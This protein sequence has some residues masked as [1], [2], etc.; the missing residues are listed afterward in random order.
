LN[1]NKLVAYF[2][3]LLSASLLSFFVVRTGLDIKNIFILI[4]ILIFIPTLIK[5]E[6]GLV[7]IIISALFSPD[8]ILGMTAYR[9]ITLRIE[10][11]CLFLVIIAWLLRTA[12]SKNIVSAFKT[13][14]T[15]PYML[16]IVVCIVST[17]IAS[18]S[19]NMDLRYSFLTI[20]K[21]LEYFIL[22]LMA[23][24]YMRSLKQAKMFVAVFFL[25]VF[26]V[27]LL[28]NIFVNQQQAA[29]TTFFR[30][31][32][33]VDTRAAESAGTLGGYLLFMMCVAGG[34]LIYMRSLPVRAFL[35][36]VLILMFRAFLFTLSRG[37]Y[38][39]FLPAWFTLF[40]FAKKYTFAY[41]SVLFLI[42]IIFLMPSMV[43]DR[44]KSTIIVK[45][46]AEG[47]SLK[48][49]DS[50]QMRIDSWNDVVFRTFPLNPIFG[51][52][53]GMRFIDGQYVTSLYEAGGVG[54][55]LFMVVLVRLFKRLKGIVKDDMLK[56]S[57]F[58]M[59]LAVGVLAGYIGLLL[60]AIS[61]NTFIIIRIME[62][63]WFMT[64]IV[65]ALPSLLEKEEAKVETLAET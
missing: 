44:V 55:I 17:V 43:R 54:F 18:Y 58:S 27:A 63:F 6:V 37:S 40:Y 9:E 19:V 52:G 57:R 48:L 21:Y 42:I 23:R 50:P 46:S 10:D 60:H 14:L 29:G 65:L 32:P 2:I 12:F 15:A 22:F 25:V 35:I 5:P 1:R 7:L 26:V 64:A 53:A 34:L 59:G 3:I 4:F 30:T 8:L 16:Y 36:C 11:M 20:I 45:E 61:C 56:N 24:Y 28:N 33:P 41:L 49:D 38:L 51:Y 62:P 13:P 47:T 31:S 39:A